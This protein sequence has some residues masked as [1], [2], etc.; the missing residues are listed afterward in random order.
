M[1]AGEERAL[2]R[3]PYRPTPGAQPLVLAGRDEEI[4]FLFSRLHD[5]PE[6]PAD[7]RMTGLRGIGKTALLRRWGEESEARGWAL[8]NIGIDPRFASEV[9]L[10]SLLAQH[11]N[12]KRETL[13]LLAAARGKVSRAA[14]IVARSVKVG[15]G[16]WTAG[17]GGR[18]E[19]EAV[20]LGRVLTELVETALGAGKTGLLFCVDEAHLLRDDVDADEFPL[21]LLLG[22]I[23]ELQVAGLPIALVLSGLPAL[24]RNLGAARPQAERLFRGLELG[25]LDHNS[26]Y[27]AFVGPLRGTGI[28][29]NGDVVEQIIAEVHGY[30]HFIQVYGDEL[31]T[32]AA[33][34]NARR[35]TMKLL[36]DTR[37]T[38]NRRIEVDIYSFRM[39]QLAPA[40]RDLL[41]AAARAGAEPLTLDS[42]AGLTP[43]TDRHS[44]ESSLQTLVDLGV[45]FDRADR[46]E[47]F[48][49]VPGFEAFL[50]AQGERWSSQV[51]ARTDP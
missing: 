47:F 44:V 38:I 22:T 41:I 7:I 42:I 51:P 33:S 23:I 40:D 29:A 5:S 46:G 18:L 20:D 50:R 31:W 6:I 26:S 8:A 35:M 32:A 14:E 34:R 17:I 10:A 12:R 27:E 11:A 48:Y 43:G 9:E 25:R 28:N 39:T 15:Y 4:R 49:T 36:R 19:E 3:N 16:E 24:N 37:A 13:S 45:L 2:I 21:S 1:P 30:P